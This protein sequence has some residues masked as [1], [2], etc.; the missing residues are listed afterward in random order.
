MSYEKLYYI[1]K[2]S[3]HFSFRWDPI[4]D[5]VLSVFYGDVI[6]QK[7]SGAEFTVESTQCS[8]SSSHLKYSHR[9]ALKLGFFSQFFSKIGFISLESE[10]QA[11]Y[12]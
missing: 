11:L 7:D 1:Y 8:F 5:R 9:V 6:P 2:I 10:A 12:L 4:Y 3:M